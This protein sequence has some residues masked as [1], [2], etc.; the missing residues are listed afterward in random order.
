[1]DGSTPAGRG[2]RLDRTEDGVEVVVHGDDT[3]ARLAVRILERREELSDAALRLLC[4]FLA[5]R[6]ERE[7]TAFDLVSVEVLAGTEPDGA[8][9]AL[10]YYFAPDT[11]PQEY[12]YTYFE[13][14][15]GCHAPPQRPF[16]PFRFTVGFH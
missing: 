2:P 15:F 12:G 11:D 1:M 4:A 13:V 16:R 9:F 5:E 3:R 10:R 14:V 7:R 6:F 8:D